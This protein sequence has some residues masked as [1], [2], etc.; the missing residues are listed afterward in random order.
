MEAVAFVSD[1]SLP[2]WTTIPHGSFESHELVGI[3][4]NELAEMQASSTAEVIGRLAASNPLLITD[5]ARR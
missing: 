4:P 2:A 5:P 1:P 3:T